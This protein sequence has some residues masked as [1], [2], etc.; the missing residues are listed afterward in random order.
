MEEGKRIYSKKIEREPADSNHEPSA[1]EA[2]ASTQGQREDETIRRAT[3]E[4]MLEKIKR[5]PNRIVDN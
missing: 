5:K 2:T 4:T 1:S 3:T